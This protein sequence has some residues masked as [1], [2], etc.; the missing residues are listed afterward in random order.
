MIPS[1]MWHHHNITEFNHV[2][3]QFRFYCDACKDKS[4]IG[5]S[6]YTLVF[7][8]EQGDIRGSHNNEC[9]RCVMACDTV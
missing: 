5:K 9:D 6:G 1:V 4:L 7:K 2:V 3:Q 8:T